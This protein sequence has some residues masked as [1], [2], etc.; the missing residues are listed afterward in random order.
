LCAV[1]LYSRTS[2]ELFAAPS[3]PTS[4]NGSLIRFANDLMRQGSGYVSKHIAIGAGGYLAL[5][6]SAV[7]AA[8]GVRRFRQR[9]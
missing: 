7:L 8:Q 4:M 6:G 1:A 9:V 2:G 3:D 5:I